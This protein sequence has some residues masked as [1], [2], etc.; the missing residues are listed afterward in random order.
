MVVLVLTALLLLVSVRCVTAF[1]LI[2][3]DVDGTLV[4][5]RGPKAE[6][7]AHAQAFS[8]AV[9]QVFGQPVPPI[10]DVLRRDQYHGSTDGLILLR[11]ARE[12]LGIHPA[13]AGSK[14]DQL[15][16]VMYESF[17][18]LPDEQVSKGIEPL[19]GVIETL[20]QLATMK[21]SVVCGLVTGNVEGIARRKMRAVGVYQTGALAKA[22]P[23]QR[24][25]KGSEDLAFLGGFGS[26]YCS[27]D[28]DQSAR[29][30]LDRGEQIAIAASRC[31]SM[32]D[33]KRVVHVGD[34][35]SDVLAAKAF[36]ERKDHDYSVGMVAV[37]TGS[38]SAEELEKL[39]GENVPGRWECA[40]LEKGI[41]D[42]NFL[43]ACLSS[44]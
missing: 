3:F 9:S 39:A 19:P 36:S 25:W 2:T 15:M 32:C 18:Q 21:E 40:V 43:K 35:P 1:T 20:E 38:F 33:L 24:N 16:M 11:L 27:K 8:Y 4:A 14:L 5:G 13:E 31:Q 44:T 7:S 41:G 42:S 10:A 6:S 17:R 30:Y 26:D 23:S 34:A 28:I 22:C 29:N 12:A 37:A